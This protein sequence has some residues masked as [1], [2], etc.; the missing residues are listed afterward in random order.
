MSRPPAWPVGLFVGV[1]GDGPLPPRAPN[2]TRPAPDN[3]NPAPASANTSTAQDELFAAIEGTAFHT[4]LI[5]ERMEE[6]GVP[7]HRIINAG[8]IPQKNATLN[9]VYASVI[10]KPILVPQSDPTSIGS[11]IFAFLAAGTYPTVEEAQAAL[12]PSY[13]T[14]EPDPR[15]A[16]VYAEMFPI[17]RKLYFAMGS[18]DAGPAQ[19]SGL[20]PALRRIATQAICRE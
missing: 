2:T 6:Y 4:R 3:S 13:A 18:K 1:P 12:C 11:A 16:T 19:M 9:R 10:N 5:L 20:L 8:G 17:F 14:V 15:D 7:V